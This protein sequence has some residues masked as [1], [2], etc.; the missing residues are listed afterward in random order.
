MIGFC[1]ENVLRLTE[2]PKTPPRRPKIAPDAP[3]AGAVKVPRYR[4][5]K[6]PAI[7]LIK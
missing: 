6:P 2:Y 1:S 5:A 3:T 7:P 4:Y